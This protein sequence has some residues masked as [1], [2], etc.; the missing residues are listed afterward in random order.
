M[1]KVI[2]FFTKTPFGTILFDRMEEHFYSCMTALF[3]VGL[4]QDMDDNLFPFVS[5]KPRSLAGRHNF[6]KFFSLVSRSPHA[7]SEYKCL[8]CFILPARKHSE[9][10][11]LH[12]LH[13]SHLP[14][15]HSS[16]HFRSSFWQTKLY[17]SQLYILNKHLLIFNINKVFMINKISLRFPAHFRG[18][19]CPSKLGIYGV[20]ESQWDFCQWL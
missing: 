12:Y 8:F 3:W 13:W 20:S 18:R 5:M 4:F 1:S 6:S 14:F 10:I 9:Q 7:F 2:I 19:V 15:V 17:L 11:Y 16:N